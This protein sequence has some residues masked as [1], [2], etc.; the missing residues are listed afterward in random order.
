MRPPFANN[1]GAFSECLKGARSGMH[2][3]SMGAKHPL[4]QGTKFASGGDGSTAARAYDRT[5]YT[6]RGALF[7]VLIDYVG[8]LAFAGFVDQIISANWFARV[9]PH[10]ERS[11]V[12]E[13]ETAVW[14]VERKGAHAEIR[15]DR[16]DLIEA[17]FPS[18]D[19]EVRKIGVVQA[20]ASAELDETSLCGL[21]SVRV[22][23]QAE[24]A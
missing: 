11:I 10:V 2:T 19:I 13:T 1:P 3:A 14:I 6:P 7:S 16:I 17:R 24:Q 4:Q 15:Q 8:Q 21:E 5:C 12:A 23:I 20:R 18:F 9:H 22:A